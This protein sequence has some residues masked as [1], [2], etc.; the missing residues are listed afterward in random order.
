[1]AL[2]VTA[3]LQPVPDTTPTLPPGVQRCGGPDLAMSANWNPATAMLYIGLD[4]S[5]VSSATCYLQGPPEIEL[6]D[7]ANQPIQ[8]TSMYTCWN[9]IV[10]KPSLENWLTPL[11]YELYV[12]NLQY[13]LQPQQQ[14]YVILIMTNW[15]RPVVPEGLTFRLT[16][17]AAGGPAE[18]HTDLQGGGRCG[19]SSEPPGLSISQFQAKP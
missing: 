12:L 13:V 8:M 6:L 9:C 3:T 5:N 2:I 11:P 10:P 15:C 17:S 14:A 18:L 19:A 16:T 4:I 7:G 1:M